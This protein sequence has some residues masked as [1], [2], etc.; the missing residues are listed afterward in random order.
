M[1]KKEITP[2]V[3]LERLQERIKFWQT[4]AKLHADLTELKK[5]I[6]AGT[7]RNPE[8]VKVVNEVIDRAIAA[9]K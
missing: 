9:I 4:R 5:K 2:E 1:A 7:P 3:K 8:L 6:E